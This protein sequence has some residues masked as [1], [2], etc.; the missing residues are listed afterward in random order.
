MTVCE[1]CEW[2]RGTITSG[3]VQASMSF[4]GPGATEEVEELWSG[5]QAEKGDLEDDSEDEF[6]VPLNT[7]VIITEHDDWARVVRVQSTYGKLS[8]RER[9]AYR[10]MESYTSPKSKVATVSTRRNEA[11]ENALD[12]AQAQLDGATGWQSDLATNGGLLGQFEGD[13][14]VNE[15]DEGETSLSDGLG[16]G[17]DGARG[18]ARELMMSA[19][20]DDDSGIAAR[21]AADDEEGGEGTL[22]GEDDVDDVVGLASGEGSEDAENLPSVDDESE[23]VATE[24]LE[25]R[26]PIATPYVVQRF[27][28]SGR[29]HGMHFC[30][31]CDTYT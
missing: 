27:R 28:A 31:A 16:G 15:G 17:L 8:L 1:W 6:G 13:L 9:K 4:E 3:A 29:S 23:G 12:D 11:L 30:H 20:E 7:P 2:L 24:L 10:I 14:H 25:V 21:L 22:S 5:Q 19:S 18:D 26:I